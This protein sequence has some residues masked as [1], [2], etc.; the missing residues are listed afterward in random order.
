MI[1]QPS[2]I[3]NMARFRARPP[4]RQ[5]YTSSRR[6]P[7][8]SALDR[9]HGQDL[10]TA[11]SSGW[12]P[13]FAH[14]DRG[15]PPLVVALSSKRRALLVP[16]LL[17][18]GAN[19]WSASLYGER[20]NAMETWVS[21]PGRLSSTHASHLWDV[22]WTH[23][24]EL[25][26]PALSARRL[27]KVWGRDNGCP[28]LAAQWMHSP[29]ALGHEHA[30]AAL[31]Q[32]SAPQRI[33]AAPWV[34]TV[35]PHANPRRVW[36]LSLSLEYDVLMGSGSEAR[37]AQNL[38]TA[39]EPVAARSG[40]AYWVWRLN[41]LRPH[42]MGRPDA[43]ARWTSLARMRAPW[44]PAP[45]GEEVWQ[46]WTASFSDKPES[47]PWDGLLRLEMGVDRCWTPSAP[48]VRAHEL[49]QR[50]SGWAPL[51]PLCWAV[52]SALCPTS[53]DVRAWWEY[54]ENHHIPTPQTLGK[55]PDWDHWGVVRDASPGASADLLALR[56]EWEVKLLSCAT[57]A[58]DSGTPRRARV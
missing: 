30:L 47:W 46:S 20:R 19:P 54:L 50:L 21:A 3:D 12:Q 9:G 45:I 43:P 4:G 11:L 2:Q 56:R 42:L 16:A 32:A 31:A 22:A 58:S 35:L 41:H 37:Q 1:G 48:S 53:A 6:S 55:V 52:G 29:L 7:F 26:E 18:A 27:W 24:P 39:V 17:S 49:A 5:R 23:F 8:W 40:L 36:A 33:R 57:K 51:S 15:E 28:D 34:E 25:P 14:D 10:A 38:W 13:E 44:C